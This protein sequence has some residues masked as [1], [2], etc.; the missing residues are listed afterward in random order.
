MA[1][2]T[3]EQQ[4][5]IA[6]AN[7]RRRAAEA[8]EAEA[9]AAKQPEGGFWAGAK[10]VAQSVG[11]GLVRGV[12]ETAMAP[13]TLKRLVEGGINKGLDAAEG[14]IRPVSDETKARR[15]DAQKTNVVSGA[16]N[17]AQDAVRGKMDE[18]LYKPETTAGKYAET[19]SSFVPAVANPLAGAR[20]AG[21]VISHALR[22]ALPGGAAS[23]AAGQATEGT[24]VE[25][26]ARAAGGIAGGAAGAVIRPGH[27]DR[28]IGRSVAG[29]ND[30]D[31][32][33]AEALA[34]RAARSNMPLT[35]DEAIQSATGGASRVGDVRRIVESTERGGNVLSPMM[36]AR[37][38]Q[39]DTL[40]RDNFRR[41]APDTN[42]PSLQGTRLQEGANQV[43][44]DARQ[45]NNRVAQPYYD[46]LIGQTM[47]PADYARL[48]ANPSYAAALRELRGEAELAP[49]YAQLPD[50]DLS[51]VNAVVKR[52]DIR[53][54]RTRGTEFVPGDREVAGMQTAARGDADTAA[55]AVSPDW[56][57]ARDIVRQ[58]N[59]TIIDPLKAGPIGD[60]ARTPDVGQQAAA[61][62]RPAAERETRQAVTDLNATAP[63]AV[64]SVVRQGVEAP[65]NKTMRGDP[66]APFQQGPDSS[67]NAARFA[68][69]MRDDPQKARNVIAAIETA[70]GPQAAQSFL[71]MLDIF[72]ATGWR[73]RPGSKTAFN[74]EAL[75][76]ASRGGIP[77]I[78]RAIVK[79]FSTAE[80]AFSKLR[81]GRQSD[82]LAELLASGPEGVQ[83]LQWLARNVADAPVRDA[84]VRALA[85]SGQVTNP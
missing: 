34:A 3:I 43:L 32:A 20:T 44:T 1:E 19:I 49:R 39:A 61:L 13:A 35:A 56:R 17:S 15:A 67:F 33:R 81:L 78:A 52:L 62:L 84:L 21:Q 50:N 5:A 47:P 10:D 36:A 37:A 68:K 12:A 82:R 30:A 74:A 76:E 9:A 70:A 29:V 58:G 73:Q 26:W 8:A 11:S 85:T 51:V 46:D 69:Q 14:L 40:A 23:E 45:A 79:P 24:W 64:R 75:Q 59:E 57:T 4:R 53:A 71:D 48:A 41:I 83:R 38:G 66:N 2:M 72:G 42:E 6:L 7:A 18:V 60:I 16:I 25:P 77:G 27:A 80:D 65:Y 28:M 31:F 54:D 22:Y 63:E 55:A